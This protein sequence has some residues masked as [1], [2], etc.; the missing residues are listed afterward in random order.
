M[1]LPLATG[2]SAWTY[3]LGVSMFGAV[4]GLPL[5]FAT[6]LPDWMALPLGLLGALWCFGVIFLPFQLRKLRASDL[7]LGDRE[8]RILG[9]PSH[10]RTIP[11]AQARLAMQYA[12]PQSDMGVLTATL[13]LDGATLV[14]ADDP[15][16][17]ASLE[18]LVALV[19]A[20]RA[21]EIADAQPPGEASPL[22]CPSCGAPATPS[23]QESTRCRACG[24]RAPVPHEVREKVS[25]ERALAEARTRTDRAIRAL[26]D[27]PRPWRVNLALLA[28]AVPVVFTW[29]LVGAFFDEFYQCRGVFRW[30]DGIPMFL[31]GLGLST[32]GLLFVRAQIEGRIAYRVLVTAYRASRPRTSGGPW[33]CGFC[34]GP[35]P[36]TG[37]DRALVRCVFCATDQL[38]GI[39]LPGRVAPAHERTRDLEHEVRHRTRSRRRYRALGVVAVALVAAGVLTLREPLRVAFAQ[40]SRNTRCLSQPPP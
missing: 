31:G 2:A 9:G 19:E 12:K 32:G 40:P 23:E 6:K 3:V 15:E 29:P 21:P 27:Q 36:E 22:P 4:A 35:L 18:A 16:E 26:L 20:A 10:G 14:E 39:D 13:T 11:L 1:R 5:L 28:C 34:G 24:Q 30:T 7:V 25:A 17:R 37:A 38:L 8:V 33:G